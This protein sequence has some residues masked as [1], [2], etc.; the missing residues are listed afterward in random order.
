MAT[1]YKALKK[2]QDKMKKECSLNKYSADKKNYTFIV[3]NV[4][5][6]SYKFIILIF[7]LLN[8]FE[9]RLL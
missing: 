1:S 3:K 4:S 8:E 7:L 6:N 5:R 2:L 9:N